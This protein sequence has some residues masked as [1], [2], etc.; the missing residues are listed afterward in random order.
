VTN[1]ELEVLE[2]A[3]RR[4]RALAENDAA[5]LQRLHHAELLWTTHR[6]EVLDR[7]RYIEGNT[8]GALRWKSQRLENVEIRIFESC[9]VLT[10]VVIDDVEQGGAA[11]RFRL[12]VTQVWSRAGG[13]WQCVA[14]HAGPRI[15]QAKG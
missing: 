4:A 6:G 9:A 1:D 3:E 10:A 8:R 14:G 7:E 15:N 13:S 11:E 12:R 2:A 5:E